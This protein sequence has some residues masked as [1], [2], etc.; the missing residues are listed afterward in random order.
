MN[1]AID[2][3]LSG[4]SISV[5]NTMTAN[6]K[7]KNGAIA[8][9][10]WHLSYDD[11]EGSLHVADT[12]DDTF[13]QTVRQQ[14]LRT[15]GSASI[16]ALT[17]PHVM[18]NLDAVFDAQWQKAGAVLDTAGGSGSGTRQILQ[19]GAGASPRLLLHWNKFQ[20]TVSVP[21]GVTYFH[22]ADGE[23]RYDKPMLSFR[24]YTALSYKPSSRVSLDL[25]A[26]CGESMPQPLSLMVQERYTNYRSSETDDSL[27]YEDLMDLQMGRKYNAFFSRNLRETDTK[28][29]ESFNTHMYFAAGYEKSFI[30]FDLLL[31]HEDGTLTET[32]R[33]PYTTEV[34]EYD[35]AIPA[36]T[37]EYLPEDTLTV[38]GYLCQAATCT[39]GG[40]DWKV[41]YTD[42]IPLPYGPWK[43]AGAPGLIL[44]AMDTENNFVFESVGLTQKSAPIIRYDW[45]RRKM[46]KDEWRKFER[47][48]Y[49]QA[50][51]FARS[52]G[53][54]ILIVSDQ[55]N[56]RLGEN[57]NW[58]EYHITLER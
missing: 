26:M 13:S 31:G 58:S 44:K 8:D 12:A 22:S 32:N 35:E 6:Y 53:T 52:T 19:L 39:Y 20:W 36:I 42:R 10:S 33:L 2:Q 21:V 38:M 16:I 41:Y 48:V 14:V 4:H 11:R 17:V 5:D 56:R 49:E 43:L 28:N 18:F 40:R 15:D 9:I 50:G 27:S 46:K 54:R 25:T 3:R 51:V 45:D 55:G 57:D 23:W 7:R 34:I 24:P 1:E 47:R 37:W 30:G 29:T